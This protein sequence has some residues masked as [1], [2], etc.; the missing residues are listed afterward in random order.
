[1]LSFTDWIPSL[2]PKRHCQS[3]ESKILYHKI[4]DARVTAIFHDNLGKPVPECL[5]FNGTRMSPFWI[6]L[7]LRM[8]EMTVTTLLQSN[9]YHQQTNTQHFYKPDAALPVVQPTV[10][11]HI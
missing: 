5:R 10:P 2:L 1:M 6:F 9:Q 4:N 11:E 8:T 3:T 7:E